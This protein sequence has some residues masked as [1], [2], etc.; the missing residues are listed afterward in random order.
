MARYHV[1]IVQ[2]TSLLETV[3]D[4]EQTFERIWDMIPMDRP[5]RLWRFLPELG[6]FIKGRKADLSY[7]RKNLVRS[8][9]IATEITALEAFAERGLPVPE[10]VA[11]GSERRRGIST[12][13]FLMLRLFENVIDLERYL[14]NGVDTERPGRRGAVFVVVGELIRQLHDAGCVH[15]DLSH[16]NIL[17]HLDGEQPTVRLIDCP[18]G[19]FGIP[20]GRMR[21][22]RREDLFRI[23][24]SVLRAGATEPEVVAML[25][26]A[27]VDNV[28]AA[29][30]IARESLESGVDRSY[31]RRLWLMTG[32]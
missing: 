4:P 32:R 13:S 9:R 17:V 1:E 16:R 7:S 29:I 21:R 3:P 23:T 15:R 25:E 30:E 8:R 24:R 19:R 20:A 18:H 5:K 27:A 2:P 31:R 26:S 10:I 11:W 22:A 14:L 12:R 6:L 28:P